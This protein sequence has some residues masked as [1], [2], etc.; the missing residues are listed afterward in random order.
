MWPGDRLVRPARPAMPQQSPMSAPKPWLNPESVE[1]DALGRREIRGYMLWGFLAVVV[2]VFELLAAYDGDATPW[3]TLSSTAG[4]LQADHHW[5]ALPILGGLV[6]LTARI[7]FYPW[8][9]R[10]PES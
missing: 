4:A 7:V 5:T 6:I 3:P 9:Y 10:R 8:P 1:S 2:A